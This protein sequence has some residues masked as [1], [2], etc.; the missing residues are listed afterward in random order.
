MRTDQVFR[1][2]LLLKRV[3]RTSLVPGAACSR[4]ARC[5]SSATS[6]S[7]TAWTGRI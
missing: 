4:S 5:S 6:W 3:S 2:C 1:R 7:R